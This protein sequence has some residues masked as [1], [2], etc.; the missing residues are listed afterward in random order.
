MPSATTNTTGTRNT[1]RAFNTC[2]HGVV[3]TSSSESV[4]AVS[5]RRIRYSALVN[6]CA[7]TGQVRPGIVYRTR[8]GVRK[9]A[10]TATT[11]VN[12][13]ASIQTRVASV[14]TE[15]RDSVASVIAIAKTTAM[16]TMLADSAAAT[17]SPIKPA[18][19][20]RG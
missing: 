3:K 18:T 2:I 17:N 11:P 5:T 13:S 14:E 15:T 4:A 12:A 8:P 1:R 19:F 7:V 16:T 20:T 6:P 9:I 10:G